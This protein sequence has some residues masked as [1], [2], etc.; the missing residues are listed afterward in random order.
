[1]PV[2]YKPTNVVIS[3]FIR[4]SGTSAY[5]VIYSHVICL[6]R[7]DYHWRI[8]SCERG[9]NQLFFK[10]IYS[11]SL[12]PIYFNVCRRLLFEK[13]QSSKKNPLLKDFVDSWYPMEWGVFLKYE[14]ASPNPES[15]IFIQ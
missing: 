2:T 15:A 6:L 12:R 7:P 9:N 13:L 8:F 1:M 14:M 3:P 4:Y 5:I 10:A 11:D